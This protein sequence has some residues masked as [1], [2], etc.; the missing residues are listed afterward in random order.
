VPVPAFSQVPP[1]LPLAQAQALPEMF[2]LLF[3]QLLHHI[4]F[5]L[6]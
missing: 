1:V 6:L 3:P 5:R 4:H 2:L